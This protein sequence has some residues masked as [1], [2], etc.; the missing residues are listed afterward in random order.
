MPAFSALLAGFALGA[1][2]FWSAAAHLRRPIRP[3]AGQALLVAVLL[4]LL[5][6]APAVALLINAEPDWAY[7]YLI[8]PSRCRAG[9]APGWCCLRG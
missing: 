1:G 2:L 9:S 5:S 8:R 7:A 6:Y 4:G 3:V